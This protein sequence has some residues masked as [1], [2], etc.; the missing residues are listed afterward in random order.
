MQQT[1]SQLPPLPPETGSQRV[2]STIAALVAVYFV[3]GF[4]QYLVPSVL[5]FDFYFVCYIAAF[6]AVLVWAVSQ[7]YF[8]AAPLAA[9]YSALLLVGYLT[10]YRDSPDLLERFNY[11]RS[12]YF[13]GY[14]IA[15]VICGLIIMLRSRLPNQLVVSIQRLIPSIVVSLVTVIFS[16]AIV[17]LFIVP[18]LRIF[19][20]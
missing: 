5:P 8:R 20:M 12:I 16:Y 1:I 7:G 13:M 3:Y 19:G 2:V 17:T 15:F 14:M 10:V 18:A 9:F 4:G 11:A 6:I